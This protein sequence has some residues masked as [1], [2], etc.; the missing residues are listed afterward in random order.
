MTPRPCSGLRPSANLNRGM[1]TAFMAN[2]F[3]SGFGFSVTAAPRACSAA[4]RYA[5]TCT[6]E[7]VSELPTTSNPWATESAGSMSF[8][9]RCGRSS[10]SRSV[11]SYSTRFSLRI[12]VRPVA[13]CRARSAS[14]S[15]AASDDIAAARSALVGCFFP[16]G[17]SSRTVRSWIFTHFSNDLGSRRSAGGCSRFKP[18]AADS[19][20]WHFTQWAS[21]N[22]DVPAGKASADRPS[23]QTERVTRATIAVRPRGR[24]MKRCSLSRTG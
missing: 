18:P 14:E 3:V 13:F 16:G 22:V 11:C 21:R 2:R 23:G 9:S 12:T 4:R 7:T 1:S 24:S 8:T 6:C 10:R 17:I 20:E 19:P 5:A 15:D